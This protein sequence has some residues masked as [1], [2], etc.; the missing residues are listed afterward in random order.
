MTRRS[1]LGG[2][3]VGDSAQFYYELYEPLLKCCARVISF[4][5]DSDLVFVGRSP[6]SI[7]DYLSGLLSDTSWNDR[8]QLLHFS[9]RYWKE[10]AIRREHP[11]GITAMRMYLSDLG[12]DPRSIASSRRPKAFVD[13]VATGDTFG[14]LV[15]L[16]Q[17]W[18][19]DLSED[20]SAVRRRI[21]IVGITERKKTSPKTWRWQQ[22]ADWIALLEA[23]SVKNVSIPRLLWDYLGNLQDKVSPSYRPSRW[24]KPE[25]ASPSRKD[26]HL[27]AL[28]F[29]F[30][31]FERGRL[32]Q[33]RKAF[34]ALL[35]QETAMKEPWF[36][37][38]VAEIR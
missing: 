32:K 2:L 15:R 26:E 8:L 24:G 30:A 29:A 35:V 38:L 37:S 4:S 11:N 6:E 17:T 5:D 23:N 21:R 9:M 14:R 25:M 18:T 3:L 33:T 12:L 34:S 28:R 31:L 7:F 22:H 27:R 10:S 1:Q 13:L 36:R 20:W 16:L 19:D